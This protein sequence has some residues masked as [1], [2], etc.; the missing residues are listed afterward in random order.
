MASLSLSKA[1][2]KNNYLLL[3]VVFVISTVFFDLR[4]EYAYV[5]LKSSLKICLKYADL[6]TLER[7]NF[8]ISPIPGRSELVEGIKMKGILKFVPFILLI[9]LFKLGTYFQIRHITSNQARIQTKY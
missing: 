8:M 5:F 9:S 2:M 1:I 4:L 3:H 6:R 7:E